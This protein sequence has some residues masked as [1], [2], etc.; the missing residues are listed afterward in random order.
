[1]ENTT[2]MGLTPGKQTNNNK[3]TNL[4]KNLIILNGK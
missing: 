2:T 3:Q 4:I 1:V